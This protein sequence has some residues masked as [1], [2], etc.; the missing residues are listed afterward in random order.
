M[1]LRDLLINLKIVSDTKGLDAANTKLDAIK[2]GAHGLTSGISRLTEGFQ[3]LIEVMALD[4][5]KDFILAP[6][7]AADAVGDLSAR[8][9]IASDSY[10]QWTTFLGQAG[11]SAETFATAVRALTSN[12]QMATVSGGQAG[13]DF[14]QLGIALKDSKGEL[15]PISDL[16]FETGGKLAEMTNETDRAALAVNLLG[17][18]GLAMMPAFAGGTAVAREHFDAIKDLAVLYDKDFIVAADQANDQIELMKLQFQGL[19][20]Q[21][22]AALIPKVFAFAKSVGSLFDKIKALVQG[23]TAFR[24]LMLSLGGLAITG[25]IAKFGGIMSIITKL[26]AA[27]RMAAGAFL[28]FLLP[29]LILDD[30]ITGLQGGESV[31]T[32]ILKSFAGEQGAKDI[33]ADINKLITQ[34]IPALTA[35]FTSSLPIIKGVFS[36][37]IGAAQGLGQAFLGVV[38]LIAMGFVSSGEDQDL[39]FTHFMTSTRELTDGV[40]AAFEFVRSAFAVI[41]LSIR[42]FAAGV[43]TSM[44]DGFHATF[45]A[46]ILAGLAAIDNFFAK[47]G[48]RFPTLA[49]IGNTI[50]ALAGGVGGALGITTPQAVAATLPGG[51]ASS[52][53]STLTDQRTVNITVGSNATPGETGR[54][55]AAAVGA[56]LNTDRRAQ[57]AAMGGS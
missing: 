20:A 29:A 18:S 36:G 24:V 11:A 22:V 14:K 32:N 43:W 44:G 56:I 6:I 31:F 13:A 19:H 2:E 52:R 21:L 9:G 26:G 49:K 4:K 42:D 40:A 46:P 38:D 45:V 17:R 12:V 8:L 3:L 51:G 27:L 47:L 50:G 57:L 15:R 53:S 33:I 35:A 5:I 41:W 25:L 10:Q 54:A 16:L 37:I 23:T 34:V 48:D 28:R 7:E 55:T 1:A 30:I 39:M